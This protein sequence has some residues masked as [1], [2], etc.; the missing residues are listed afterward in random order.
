MV[1]GFSGLAV[2]TKLSKQFLDLTLL[3]YI[4]GA[5]G[6]SSTQRAVEGLRVFG[7]LRG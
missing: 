3:T 6:L 1:I 4:T 2:G 5:G 7:P